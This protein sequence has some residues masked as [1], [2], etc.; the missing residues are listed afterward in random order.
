MLETLKKWFALLNYPKEWEYLLVRAANKLN[1][2]QIEAHDA[3]FEWLHGQEDKSL[4]FLYALCK[5]EDFFNDQKALGIPE[6]I[7][8]DTVQE[9]RRHTRKYTDEYGNEQLGIFQIKWVGNV[10]SGRLFCLGRLEFEMKS[11]KREIEK[12]GVK[13]GD[14]VLNVHIPGTITQSTKKQSTFHFPSHTAFL[15]NIFQIST[16]KA[17]PAIRG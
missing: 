15:K 2:Q 17:S 6:N 8:I 7:I 11:I 13:I 3:P 5:C 14:C 16:I 12:Y 1:K 9:I 4:C 10:L